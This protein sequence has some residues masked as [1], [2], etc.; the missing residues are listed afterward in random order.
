M[1]VQKPIN[2]LLNCNTAVSFA[3]IAM[4]LLSGIS[5]SQRENVQHEV[6]REGQSAQVLVVEEPLDPW[7]DFVIEMAGVLVLDVSQ[8][9]RGMSSQ[10]MRQSLETPCSRPK[11]AISHES[12]A[13]SIAFT[14]KNDKMES[15]GQVTI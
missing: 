5:L 15:T 10:Q 8:L 4:N 14:V 11:S 7:A 13:T 1:G 12:K 6:R 9:T 3:Q 2:H